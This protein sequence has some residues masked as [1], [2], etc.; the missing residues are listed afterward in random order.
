MVNTQT[1]KNKIKKNYLS[2]CC[3]RVY[4]GLLHALANDIAS[5][6]FYLISAGNTGYFPK[7][8]LENVASAISVVVITPSIFPMESLAY[9]ICSAKIS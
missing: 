5:K 8:N 9:L 4:V 2:A 3:W 7:H 6:Q 1:E